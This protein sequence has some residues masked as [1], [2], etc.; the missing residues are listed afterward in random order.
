MTSTFSLAFGELTELRFVDYFGA[1][2]N[3]RMNNAQAWYENEDT[4]V[5]FSFERNRD[6]GDE[7]AENDP[8]ARCSKWFNINFYRPSY[9]IREA[10]LEVTAFVRQFD[11]LVSDPQRHGM[12]EG[13]SQ[14]DKLIS[15]WDHG[16]RFACSTLSGKSSDRD[17]IACLPS[18]RLTEIWNWNRSR[19]GLQAWIGKSMFAPKIVFVLTSDDVLTAVAW[20]D[21]IPAILPKVN[22]LFIPRHEL[23]PRLFWGQKDDMAVTSW[24]DLA[25]LLKK[26]SSPHVSGGLALSYRKPP[27]DVARFVQA[28][29]ANPQSYAGISAD[30]VLDQELMAEGAA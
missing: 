2:S 6:F 26:H 5:Y 20:P 18:Q 9:F 13:E 10:E 11:L 24:S 27:A 17:V 29:P 19:Q 25:P 12:G 21:A 15:G 3:Y 4:G 7:A 16:N 23:A 8:Q 28:L 30:Q 1:R 14:P 22:L